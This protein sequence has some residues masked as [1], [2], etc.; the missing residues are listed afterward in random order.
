MVKDP[1]D[2]EREKGNPLSHMGYSFRLVARVLSYAPF[3]RQ[4]NTYQVL[5]YIIELF[6]VP[7]S[8]LR[9]I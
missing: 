3:H 4:D 9:L 1:L 2:S 6:L 8:A 7:G 5:C